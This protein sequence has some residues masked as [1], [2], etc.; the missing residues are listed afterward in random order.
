MELPHRSDNSITL[1]SVVRKFGNGRL[2]SSLL[3]PCGLRNFVMVEPA[4]GAM[5]AMVA[6]AAGD[7]VTISATGT[8]RS[9]DQQRQLFESRYVTRN[10][11]GRTKVWNGTTY[12]Q[13]PNTAMAA[14]PG[15]SNHGFGVAADLSN[16][17]TAPIAGATLSW[18]A[19]HGPS[20]GFWNTVRSEAW[21][22]SYCLGDEVP[23]G[24]PT[25][26]HTAFVDDDVDWSAAAASG[27]LDAVVPESEIL[28]GDRG[29]ATAAVQWRLR[30]AGHDVVVDGDFGPQTEAAVRAFQQ[31]HGLTIDGRVGPS[32]WS[33]L[34]AQAEPEGA[35]PT[36]ARAAREGTYVVRP[37]DGFLRIAQR[38]LWSSDLD[39][40]TA[41]AEANGLTLSSTIVP[42]LVLE[43]PACHSTVVVP[44]DDWSTVARRLDLDTEELRSAN[45]WAG[46]AL[47]VGTV[48]Y[49][50]R[51]R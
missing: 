12:W 36:P 33:A 43:I 30:K 16:S 7:G 29:E 38:T 46:D 2:P 40:A 42:G 1:P 22:W 9:F 4:A 49:G 50:G 23:D 13:L 35:D 14:T 10:T 32:T 28:P 37:G 41:I 15:T 18:M 31:A 3:Q 17:P 45:A 47:V 21:H 26:A 11:G 19:E 6:A 20:F 25:P 51:A 24:V 8:W 48:V 27:E 39:A 34:R 44:G 5:R